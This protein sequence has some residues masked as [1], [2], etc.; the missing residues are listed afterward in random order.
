M[1]LG[2][3]IDKMLGKP[4]QSG[5]RGPG[6]YYCLGVFL[7]LLER[8]RGIRLEDPFWPGED[9]SLARVRQFWTQFLELP[10]LGDL[11]PLDVLYRRPAGA[12]HVAVVE[13]PRWVVTAEKG[14]GVVR[15]PMRDEIPRVERAYRLKA[16][17]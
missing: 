14:A 10:T 16:L 4:F 3:H 1:T 9:E 15:I 8:A 7:D 17:L 12:A 6:G 13:G 5:G 2:E 11:E